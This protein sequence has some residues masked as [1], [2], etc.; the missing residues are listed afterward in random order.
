MFYEKTIS[1]AFPYPGNKSSMLGYYDSLI[2]HRRFDAFVDAFGGSGVTS[3]NANCSH[4]VYNELVRPL[5]DLFE[6]FAI[7]PADEITAGVEAAIAQHGTGATTT[8]ELQS[9]YYALRD[10]YNESGDPVLLYALTLTSFH[11]R[12]RFNAS[13][14]MNISCGNP[15]QFGTHRKALIEQYCAR[16]QRPG[17]H[18][19]V[20]CGSYSMLDVPENALVFVDPPY[21]GSN[22]TYSNG[23]TEHDER[24]LLDWLSWLDRNG[25][26]WMLANNLSYGNE[27]L[28]L[29][30]SKRGYSMRYVPVDIA[31]KSLYMRGKGNELKARN[32][33][34]V[35][36]F[37]LADELQLAA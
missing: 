34:V 15:E 12:L 27:V 6:M 36:N 37:D 31:K 1:P 7:M 32:E 8:A 10:A 18:I 24:E 5:A 33:V 35:A 11:H 28:P 21:L 17:F 19:D 2:S 13:D 14:A 30:V 9:G 23:W 26:C 29:E 20:N 22:N 4:V 16:L 25:A 3:A